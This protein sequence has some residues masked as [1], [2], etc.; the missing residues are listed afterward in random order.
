MRAALHV[1]RPGENA[2]IRVIDFDGDLDLLRPYF[3]GGDFE[4]L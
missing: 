4:H 3:D 1:L 2:D